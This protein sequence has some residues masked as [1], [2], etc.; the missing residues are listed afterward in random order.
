MD[1]DEIIVNAFVTQYDKIFSNDTFY[2]ENKL[3]GFVFNNLVALFES[4]HISI[5]FISDNALLLE[6]EYSE[7]KRNIE[8]DCI[9]IAQNIKE[10]L[11]K[12][13][14]YLKK[15]SSSSILLQL[16]IDDMSLIK[17]FIRVENHE[18]NMLIR[19]IE[20]I[21]YDYKA[22]IHCQ[23]GRKFC[24]NLSQLKIE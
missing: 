9:I 2:S 1:K 22:D 8:S 11:I 19:I 16:F 14:F 15:F 24:D 3:R 13:H 4:L 18:E 17:F 5:G 12:Y 10:A 7:L 6:K 20:D 23:E 21:V